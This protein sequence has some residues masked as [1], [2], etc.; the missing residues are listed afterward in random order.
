MEFEVK[1]KY[2][3]YTIEQR[4]ED[5]KKI[6]DIQCSDGNWNCDEYMRGMANGL[7]LAYNTIAEPY[8]KDVLFKKSLK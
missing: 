1:S 2:E 6:V 4:I 3:E 5:L 8:G 7:L